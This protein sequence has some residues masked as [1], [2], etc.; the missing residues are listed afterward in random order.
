MCVSVS[1]C[2]CVCACVCACVCVSYIRISAHLLVSMYV[3]M[4]LFWI[5]QHGLMFISAY[6]TVCRKCKVI[7]DFLI[8]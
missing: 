1:V 5:D 3:F 2:V 8:A 4:C 6:G 7:F